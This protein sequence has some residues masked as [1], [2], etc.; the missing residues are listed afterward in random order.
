MI[1]ATYA[2]MILTNIQEKNLKQIIAGKWLDSILSFSKFSSNKKLGA[3]LFLLM[4]LTSERV[5]ES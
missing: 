3:H 1:T 5:T 4:K 2:F